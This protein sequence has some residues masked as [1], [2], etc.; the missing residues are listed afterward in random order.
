MEVKIEEGYIKEKVPIYNLT[1]H[2]NSNKLS[3]FHFIK[4]TIVNDQGIILLTSD[5]NK[6]LILIISSSHLGRGG[7]K[8]TALSKEEFRFIKEVRYPSFSFLY[9]IT[10]KLIIKINDNK[11]A[12]NFLLF[13][14]LLCKRGE[15][16]AKK[17]CKI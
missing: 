2:S 9:Q 5:I 17:I 3:I 12:G 13:V 15:N 4:N 1:K 11:L 6:I 14:E 8:Q 10:L 7:D 16:Y